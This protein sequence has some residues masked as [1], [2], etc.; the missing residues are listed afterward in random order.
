MIVSL[1]SFHA[2]YWRTFFFLKKKLLKFFFFKI[3]I[4]CS[5]TNM[6]TAGVDS[7]VE[8]VKA[9][10]FFPVFSFFIRPSPSFYDRSRKWW[11]GPR[12]EN[13]NFIR[14][15]DRFITIAIRY[16]DD[17]MPLLFCFFFFPYDPT[18]LG[19]S[20]REPREVFHWWIDRWST[21]RSDRSI[22][23]A[24]KKSVRSAKR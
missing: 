7:T 20:I 14:F 12:K 16:N 1:R 13:M 9:A 11:K 15:N 2:S 21:F 10:I 17:S 23:F 5:Q 6:F 8:S 3:P 24:I 22:F 4:L 19:D 18:G